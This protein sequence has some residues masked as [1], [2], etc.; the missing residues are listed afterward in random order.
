MGKDPLLC[1]TTDQS[2]HP[3]TEITPTTQP[4]WAAALPLFQLGSLIIIKNRRCLGRP[5]LIA[6]RLRNADAAA[7]AV[8]VGV[9][10]YAFRERLRHHSRRMLPPVEVVRDDEDEDE[11]GHPDD[12]QPFG[13]AWPRVGRV[14]CS[15]HIRSVVVIVAVAV[16]SLF[17][18]GL[19]GSIWWIAGLAAAARA[20]CLC[21]WL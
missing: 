10:K 18:L 8:D 6:Q 1:R 15:Q 3:S 12:D 19:L 16:S 11:D 21:G 4:V 2:S 20:R 17:A 14:L 7:D 9:H 13:P 5:D